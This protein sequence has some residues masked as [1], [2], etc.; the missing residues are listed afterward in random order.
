MSGE[1]A[2]RRAGQQLLAM[3]PLDALATAAAGPERGAAI[4]AAT[5]EVTPCGLRQGQ[6]G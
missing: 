4:R 2:Q 1:A 3:L 5:G 6:T